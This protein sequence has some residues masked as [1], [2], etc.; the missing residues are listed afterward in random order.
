MP[1]AGENLSGDRLFR[2]SLCQ[3]SDQSGGSTGKAGSA[4]VHVIVYHISPS[5]SACGA[6]W[7]SLPPAP[8][9]KGAAVAATFDFGHANETVPFPPRLRPLPGRQVLL[10]Y[11]RRRARVGLR[12]RP[13]AGGLA[14]LKT[15]RRSLAGGDRPLRPVS[16]RPS[17]SRATSPLATASVPGTGAT[18][19]KWL[20]NNSTDPRPRESLESRLQRLPGFS[21][22]SQRPSLRPFVR[23]YVFPSSFPSASQRASLRLSFLAS[24]SFLL[25]PSASQRAPLQQLCWF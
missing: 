2:T 13:R 14:R 6:S 24:S 11:G 20:Q 7:A 10:G 5:R 4:G 25:V 19:L 1:F 15:G 17:S 16:D 12:D 23:L 3:G 9:A 21:S 22:A 8:A 18:V